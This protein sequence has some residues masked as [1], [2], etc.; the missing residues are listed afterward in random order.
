MVLTIPRHYASSTQQEEDHV[1]EIALQN[2][3]EETQEI[4]ARS[5]QHK[6]KFG[7]DGHLLKASIVDV[8]CSS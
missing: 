5:Q 6:I 4:F 2:P 8:D 1:E 7:D 3:N